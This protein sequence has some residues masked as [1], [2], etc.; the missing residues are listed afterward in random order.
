MSNGSSANEKRRSKRL[1]ANFTIFYQVDK[2]PT[3]VMNVGYG[4]EIESL[5]LDLSEG[6]M[7][8]LTN[9]D[10]PVNTVLLI[11]FILINRALQGDNRVIKL[12]MTGIVC[13][14]QL[15]ENEEHRLGIRFSEISEKDKQAI[16][17]FIRS[18]SLK[19]T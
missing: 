4:I 19:K 5:M 10:L 3:V 1:R 2:P 15:C 7:A 14:N 9:Y 12:S 11:K 13:Y 8:I 16:A 17:D 18:Y 6:G